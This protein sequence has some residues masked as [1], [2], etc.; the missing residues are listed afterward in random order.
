MVLSMPEASFS[1]GVLGFWGFGVLFGGC[2][3]SETRIIMHIVIVESK[4]LFFIRVLIFKHVVILFEGVL[5]LHAHT[6]RMN[7][8]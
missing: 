1:L 4:A 2:I 7:V 8:R 5:A 3:E 6:W